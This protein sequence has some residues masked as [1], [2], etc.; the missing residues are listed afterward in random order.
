M[1]LKSDKESKWSFKS[2]RQN[3][4]KKLFK[5]KLFHNLSFLE[6][7]SKQKD[8]IFRFKSSINICCS[9]MQAF[10]KFSEFHKKVLNLWK[11]F[12]PLLKI[13]RQSYKYFQSFQAKTQSLSETSLINDSLE[14]KNELMRS[15]T[16]IKG[17][18]RP[19][20]K[21]GMMN[22]RRDSE[23]VVTVYGTWLTCLPFCMFKNRF[24]VKI[25]SRRQCSESWTWRWR[26]F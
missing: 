3:I 12:E 13:V 17:E 23:I 1:C 2:F 18:K 4:L 11:A 10:W 20:K 7:L 19:K 5:F 24:R 22:D 9:R 14:K 25:P 21:N 26:L 6:I 8:L 16:F 15:R